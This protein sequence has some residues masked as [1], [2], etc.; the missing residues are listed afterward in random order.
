MKIKYSQSSEGMRL[1]R[2]F[3][4]LC[5]L[6]VCLFFNDLKPFLTVGIPFTGRMGS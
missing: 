2:V 4:F 1:Q 5:F 6:F 3:L